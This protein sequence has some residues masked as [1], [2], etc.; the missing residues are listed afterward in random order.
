MSD[1]EQQL[2]ATLRRKQPPTRFEHRVLERVAALRAPPWWVRKWVAAVICACVLMGIGAGVYWQRHRQA[3]RAHREV[4]RALQITA[5]KLALVERVA[6]R[7][8]SKQE[9]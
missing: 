3:E 6:A 7:N 9:Q 1:I 4:V 2:R 8:L 5:E